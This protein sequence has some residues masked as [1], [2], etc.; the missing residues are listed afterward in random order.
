M[1]GLGRVFNTIAVADGV[2]VPLVDAGAVS[3]ICY[4]GAGDTFTVQEAQDGG[5][6]GAANLVTIERYSTSDGV[7]GAWTDRTQAAAATVTIA[8]TAGLDCAVFTIS[9]EELSAGFTHVKC[10]STSTGTVVAVLH[11]LKV[12]RAAGNLPALV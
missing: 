6:T 4:L 9:A 8:G 2:Y 7:G 11:D 1:D 5:G 12:Q 10:T 3:F